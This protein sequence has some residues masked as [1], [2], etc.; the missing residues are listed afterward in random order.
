M[1]A[2]TFERALLLILIRE[3][4]GALPDTSALL[5]AHRC[6]LPLTTTYAHWR[7]QFHGTFALE[8]L[9][10]VQMLTV[11]VRGGGVRADYCE[12]GRAFCDLLS[13]HG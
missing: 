2:L 9:R 4:A 1:R 7:A 6:S 10:G 8:V 5:S 3:C 11:L 13:I 12:D